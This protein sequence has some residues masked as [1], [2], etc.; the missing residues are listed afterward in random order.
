MSGLPILIVDGSAT[1]WLAV[2]ECPY[3]TICVDSPLPTVEYEEY[4][5]GRTWV[6]RPLR[7]KDQVTLATKCFHCVGNG[8][9]T[10]D[11]YD[12]ECPNCTNGIVPFATATITDMY[13]DRSKYG[14]WWLVSVT[15]V[16][17]CK[18]K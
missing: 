6:T 2:S 8:R 16:Q 9:C 5:P 15:D 12:I 17:P 1:D 11:G 10:H 4:T 18:K 14:G 13:Y 3:E 7:V